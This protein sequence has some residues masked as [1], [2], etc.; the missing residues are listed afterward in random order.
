[1]TTPIPTKNIAET[2]RDLMSDGADFS[3]ITAPDPE[4]A[5]T[6]PV[7]VSVPHGRKVED[8]TKHMREAAQYLKPA[9]RKGTAKLATLQSLI[10]WA[11]RFKGATS[12]LYANP[13]RSAPSLTCIANYHGEGG[14]TLDATSPDET[15]NYGDH[16]GVYTFP[17]SKEWQ[18][19][20]KVS[21]KPMDKDEMAQFIEDNAKDFMNP[22]PALL[23]PGTIESQLVWEN[24]LIEIAEKIG[25]RF[26]QH[27]KLVHMSREFAV[28]EVSNLSVTSN[29]DTGESTISF[30]NEHK[31]TTGQPL[32]IPNL[33]LIAIPVFESGA[34]YRLPVRFQYRKQGGALKFS[35]TIYDPDRALDD[36][37]DEAV[38]T[39]TEATSLP[40]LE[41]TAE[42]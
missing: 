12:I 1:M 16:R 23:N 37:F 18:R 3:F 17:L 42:A 29:R 33:F 4:Q 5:L 40:V 15:A 22:T 20:M 30:V 35:L 11:N 31:D 2:V 21:G 34:L 24:R 13:D 25:G 39:A 10:D 36:A 8:L 9:R 38:K 28:H 26:G 41:G 19:W 14:A 7:L 6:A 32:Q 27:L